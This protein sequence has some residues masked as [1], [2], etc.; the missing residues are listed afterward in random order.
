[1]SEIEPAAS[2]TKRGSVWAADGILLLTAAVWGINI[3][4]FKHV[5]RGNDLFSFN[6]LRLVLALTTLT[7][8]TVAEMLI[9]PAT[10]PKSG[11][12]WFRVF[13][14]SVLNGLLYLL[15]FVN[16]VP[17]TTAGNI[18]LILASLPMWTALIS[19]VML[20]ERLPT[21]TWIGLI[22]TFMGTIIV[23]TGEVSLSSHY[24]VGNMLMLIATICWAGA[25]VVSK[26]IMTSLTPLQLATISSW[27]TVP[28]HVLIAMKGIP[29]A[30]EKL[31]SPGFFWAVVYSGV[32]S[33]GIAYATWNAG[34]RMVG[35]SHAAVFQNVVTLVAV[36]GGWLALGE[37]LMLAQILGGVLTVAGLFLMRRGRPKSNQPSVSELE[38]SAVESSG[39]SGSVTNP[40]ASIEK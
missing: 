2:E 40:A 4:V 9:W 22:V 15:I 36:L 14:F 34:V 10:K 6:A 24:F 16:A 5:D 19:L 37:E 1:M 7:V 39:P 21:V 8:L 17:M 30:V 13:F 27:L 28:I 38:K 29:S 31:S 33:T 20:K 35:A 3:L 11:I 18:A 25:T 26:P 32:C 12:P 23:T